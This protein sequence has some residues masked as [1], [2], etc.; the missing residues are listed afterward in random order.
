M[1][2]KQ[3]ILKNYTNLQSINQ[4]VLPLDLGICIPQN[5]SVRLLSHLLEELNYTQLFQAYSHLG[6]KP[7]VPPKVLFKVLVYAYMNNLYSSRMIEQA[8]RRDIHFMWLLQGYPV[9]DHNLICRFRSERL[10]DGV[11]ED[12][13]NQLVLKLYDL[14][15]ITFEHLF[16]DGTKI[17]AAS[18]RYSFVWKGSILK[19]EVKLH[20]KIMGFIPLLNEVFQTSFIPEKCLNTEML[21]TILAFL[22]KK[23]EELHVVFVHGIGKRKP[24]LQKTVETVKEFIEKQTKYTESKLILK[25]RNSYSKTD[26]DATF[27]R[28]KDDHM[29]N[30]QLKPGYNIQ[31]GV[32][33][34]Y[35]IGVDVS[36]E[37][38]DVLTLIPFL[39]KL[40][41]AFPYKYKRIIADAG[42]ESEENYE[43]LRKEKQE[44]FIKPLNYETSKKKK[45]KNAIGKRENMN[46]DEE[47]D[48]YTCH[49]GKKLIPVRKIKRKS[50]SGYEADVTQYECDECEGCPL[51]ET[52]T[53][54]KGNKTLQ[55]SKKFIQR[56]RESLENIQTEKGIILR[57]NRSIQ[58]EGAFGV[59]KEDWQFRRFLTRGKEKVLVEFMLLCFGYNVKKLHNKIQKDKCQKYLH[60]KEM[61]K[62]AS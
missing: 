41:R 60:K 62:E 53:K 55:V 10:A 48:T 38:S 44:V 18:N 59:L 46:Y 30:S 14:G 13:F 56:R 50:K 9:P 6:R 51:K 23:Q 28:M 22:L 33:A 42:Y 32:E 40:G 17:E 39:E 2:S 5:E 26:H 16:I 21:E 54:A 4:L 11:L 57:M 25:E 27:M 36:S 8:C 37:R 31:I 7:V 34:E 52:C 43:Y 12:L 19:N 29:R 49:N 20:E 1:T 45:F 61:I 24:S 47:T 35:V 58:V 15:E 3:N